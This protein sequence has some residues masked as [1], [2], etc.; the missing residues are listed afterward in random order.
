MSLLRTDEEF[1]AGSRAKFT[2]QQ[3]YKGEL[4]DL[5]AQTDI[6]LQLLEPSGP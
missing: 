4:G 2:L 1:L 3:I 5:L 6:L